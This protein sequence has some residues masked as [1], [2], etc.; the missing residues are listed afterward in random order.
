MSADLIAGVIA[1][2]F[3]I[4]VLSYLIGDNPLFRIAI[5]IFVGVSSGYVAVVA[6]WQVLWPD[7]LMPLI[8]GPASQ[9]ILLVIPLF[10]GALLLMKAWPS[11]TRLGMP[12]MGMLA[13]VG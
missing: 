12:A 10:L 5:Y 9:K 13:G 7:L 4:M 8:N 6:W 1:F 2:L 3:T 11:L